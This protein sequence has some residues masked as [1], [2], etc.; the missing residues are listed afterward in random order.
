MAAVAAPLV[1]GA[2]VEARERKVRGKLKM[3]EPG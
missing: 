2:L 3:E 1:Q